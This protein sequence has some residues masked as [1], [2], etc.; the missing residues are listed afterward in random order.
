MAENWNVVIAQLRS[1]KAALIAQLRECAD[2]LG[3]DQIDHFRAMRAFADSVALLDEM[4]HISSI[5]AGNA[6]LKEQ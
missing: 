4:S 1:E 6:S 2:T 5:E 3:A